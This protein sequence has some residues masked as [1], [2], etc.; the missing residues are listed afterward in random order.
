M[1]EAAGF[2]AVTGL[3]D[4]PEITAALMDSKLDVWLAYIAGAYKPDPK[5][6]EEVLR[7]FGG[8]QAKYAEGE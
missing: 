1:A 3:H 8:T 2:G 5:L 7:R 6:L 4:P